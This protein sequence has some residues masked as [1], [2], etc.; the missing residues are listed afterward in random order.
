MLLP[1]PLQLGSLRRRAV[2]VNGSRWGRR[3]RRLE[4]GR[5]GGRRNH[6]RRRRRDGSRLR[7]RRRR[8]NGRRR[9][10]R[11]RGGRRRGGRRRRL[12]RRCRGLRFL[13]L[14]GGADALLRCRL[15]L[16]LRQRCRCDQ[17]RARAADDHGHRCLPPQSTD[18]A[19]QRAPLGSLPTGGLIDLGRRVNRDAD[20]TSAAS[21]RT[22][23]SGRRRRRRRTRARAEASGAGSADPN[24]PDTATQPFV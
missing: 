24:P 5:R 21:P 2:L 1:D 7:R 17:E 19:S 18:D 3:R 15:G 12:C 8:L 13:R 14:G 22:T 20:G 11:R 16:W 9:G 10:R 4:D 23:R 6:H